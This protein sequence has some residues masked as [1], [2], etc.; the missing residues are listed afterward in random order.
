MLVDSHCHLNRLDENTSGDIG[1]ILERARSKG[2]E[3][4]LCIATSLDSF[5]EIKT[6]AEQHADVFCTAGVH[7]LQKNQDKIDYQLL[8]N[9]GEHSKVVAI[10]ETGLDYYYS[11]HNSDWQKQTLRLQI[12]A[13]KE[14]NKPLIIHSRDAREDT[15]SI[16]KTENAEQV[17]GILHCFTESYEMAKSAIDMGFYISFSGIFCFEYA[18]CIFS[19]ITAMNN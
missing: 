7:P 18:Q 1:T 13:A 2:V 3:K 11:A 14:L 17:G 5:D 6:I 15:L 4:F 12:N 9:Q 16:L 10:G 8:L 19:G